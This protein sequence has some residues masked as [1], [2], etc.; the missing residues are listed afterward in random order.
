[1]KKCTVLL[2]CV[3]GL[4]SPSQIDSLKNNPDNREVKI[5]GVDVREEAIG[6][7]LTDKFYKVPPGDAP[8][9]L[10]T[11]L[12]ICKKEKIDVIFPASHEEALALAKERELFKKRGTI[13]ATSNY[14]ILE[15]AFNKTAAYSF[16]LKH[17]LPCPQF[18]IVKS[19][20]NFK[21]AAQKL[22]FPKKDIVMKPS[23][24]RGGRG[25]RI[26]TNE[27]AAKFLLFE[28]PG[29]LY[30]NFNET[31]NIL[32]TLKK[33]PEL[34][35]MEYLPGIYYSVDF[36][37]KNGE[38]LIIVPKIRIEG[39]PSQTL[40]GLVKR[41]SLVE[42]I[43]SDIC[44]AFKFDYNINI[45]MKYSGKNL[46]IPYDINPRIA[47]SVAFCTA[48]G[49]NLIYYALKMALGEKIPEKIR[50]KEG[51]KMIRYFKELYA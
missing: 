19:I 14:K 10:K 25:A 20:N 33:F 18:F 27:S 3:G 45:E 13:I 49:A 40:V 51:V 39:T 28:K 8:G 47:A 2:T 12:K 50:I 4:I 37:A 31:L 36:L 11:I 42:K 44:R 16:L 43:T 7:Y 23:L 29:S 35:L 38:A 46:P 24:N 9:Y 30:A 21:K 22:G 15:L 34:I 1:M 48:A 17:H 32:Q 5:I 26:L 6:R 41:N